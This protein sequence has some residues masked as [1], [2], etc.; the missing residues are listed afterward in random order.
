MPRDGAIIFGDL[1]GKLDVLRIECAKCGARHAHPL[2]RLSRRNMTRAQKDLFPKPTLRA[3]VV[4]FGYHCLTGLRSDRSR[5]AQ[6]LHRLVPR[7]RARIGRQSILRRQSCDRPKTRPL[8]PS[9]LRGL[10][11][12]LEFRP[13]RE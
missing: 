4:V 7:A 10:H 8:A 11:G 13:S 1:I 2:Y 9:N 5:N 6:T 12:Q 3:H